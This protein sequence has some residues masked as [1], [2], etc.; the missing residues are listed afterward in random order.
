MTSPADSKR[1]QSTAE[2]HIR[3]CQAHRDL[4]EGR[5]HAVELL[6]PAGSRPSRDPKVLLAGSFDPLHVGHRRMADVAADISGQPLH[7]ELSINNADK[8]PLDAA[9]AGRRL[10]PAIAGGPPSPDRAARLTTSPVPGFAPHGLLLSDLAGFVAKSARYPNAIFAVGIDTWI[11]IADPVYYGP[12]MHGPSMELIAGQGCRFLVFGRLMDGTF[13]TLPPGN[14]G[15]AVPAALLDISSCVP[16]SLF[17]YDISSSLLRGQN[18]K[19]PP[20]SSIR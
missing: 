15:R 11:R 1:S 20:D 17:R 9:E 13:K 2:W 8:P 10:L 4:I 6:P 3:L 19:A 7:F 16:E 5:T 14:A 18:P 12:G